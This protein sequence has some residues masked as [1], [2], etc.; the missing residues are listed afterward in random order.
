MSVG[1]FKIFQFFYEWGASLQ[2]LDDI[3]DLEEDHKNGHCSY[4]TMGFEKELSSRSPGELAALIT[5]DMNHLKRLQLTYKG[6]IDS[7]RK[8]CINLKADL[9]AY[10]VDM[11]EARLDVFFSKMLKGQ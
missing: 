1:F 7:S 2:I 11:L 5:S 9:M 8:K 10:F 3:M 6:L 4:S